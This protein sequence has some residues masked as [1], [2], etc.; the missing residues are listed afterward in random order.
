M[1]PFIQIEGDNSIDVNVDLIILDNNKPILVSA[2]DI[3]IKTKKLAAD[4]ISNKWITAKLRDRNDLKFEKYI[5]IYRD[6]NFRYKSSKQGQ[7][8]HTMIYN[9]N[10]NNYIIDWNNE[11]E[12]KIVTKYLQNRLYKPITEEIVSQVITDNKYKNE[13][14]RPLEVYTNNPLFENLKAYR[15]NYNWFEQELQKLNLFVDK[16]N[17]DWDKIENIEDYLLTFAEPIKEKLKN[18]IKILYD[19]QNINMEMFKGKK[20]PFRGQVPII[21]SALEVL[22]RDRFVY[23]NVEQGG[24]KTL[25]ASK[26]N[27]CHMKEKGKNNYVTLIVAPAITLKQWKEELKNSI[28]DKIDIKIFRK[29]VDFIKWHNQTN[30]KSI[31]LLTLLLAKKHLN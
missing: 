21:Q 12:I 23:L 27:H 7:L 10:I 2:V 31:N 17:F 6:D 26:I 4:F 19:P 22:K 20:K 25:Q 18:N 9:T 30:M 24:G 16:D 3:A 13:I 29:T 14:L 8:T 1:I 11:G 5:S 28:E 15:L